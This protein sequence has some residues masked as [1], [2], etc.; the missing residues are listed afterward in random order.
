MVRCVSDGH[1]VSVLWVSGC[2]DEVVMLG[3]D[4]SDGLMLARVG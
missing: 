2:C 3:V 1:V 4:M